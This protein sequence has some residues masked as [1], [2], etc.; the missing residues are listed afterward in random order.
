MHI[1]PKLISDKLKKNIVILED[2][3]LASDYIGTEIMDHEYNTV[4]FISK[5][6]PGY[7]AYKSDVYRIHVQDV[8]ALIDCDVM[9]T[10]HRDINKWLVSYDTNKMIIPSFIDGVDCVI[11]CN[12][13]TTLNP[14]GINM[15]RLDRPTAKLLVT[16]NGY[17]LGV[18]DIDD[19]DLHALVN[20]CEDYPYS[21]KYINTGEMYTIDHAELVK[22]NARYD[23]ICKA[24]YVGRID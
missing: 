17:E 22:D 12:K 7:A 21:V 13:I 14:E 16:F 24:I 8:P 15:K 18:T 4:V 10:M 2:G 23:A 3:D 9:D 11:E 6:E 1:I 19:I 5:M 20:S